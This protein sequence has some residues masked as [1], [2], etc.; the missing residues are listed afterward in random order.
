[1]A[2]Q[3]PRVKGI[4][5]NHRNC[6]PKKCQGVE[7]GGG[8]LRM[9]SLL[10]FLVSILLAP[11]TDSR[12]KKTKQSSDAQPHLSSQSTGAGAWGRM[13]ITTVSQRI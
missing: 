12:K 7:G 8:R 6:G 10:G 2:R 9:E 4:L 1:M 11:E 5:F 13:T 3:E